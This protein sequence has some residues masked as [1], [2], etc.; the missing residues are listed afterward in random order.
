VAMSGFGVCWKNTSRNTPK[1]SVVE[2]GGPRSFD[3]TGAFIY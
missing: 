2:S 3:D 1:H